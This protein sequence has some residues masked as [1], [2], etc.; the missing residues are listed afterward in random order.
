M[1]V[2]KEAQK[3]LKKLGQAC[4]LALATIFVAV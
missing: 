2:A 3:L 4:S 1:S